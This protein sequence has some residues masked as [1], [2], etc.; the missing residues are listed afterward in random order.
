MTRE[1]RARKCTAPETE[2]IYPEIPGYG[3]SLGRKREA[4]RV[5]Y[6]SPNARQCECGA[7]PVFEQYTMDYGPEGERNVPATEF[8]AICPSCERRAKGSGSLEFCLNRWNNQIMSPDSMRVQKRPADFDT[9][10]CVALSGRLVRD[11]MEEAIRLVKRRWEIDRQLANPLLSDVRRELLY[12]EF[13][14]IRH[15][16][17]EMN[18]VFYGPITMDRDGDAIISKIRQKLYPALKPEERVTI[19]LRLERMKEWKT[20]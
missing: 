3:R 13:K 14:N 20:K 18:K 4:W 11:A 9:E 15:H 8:V 19:P 10:A 5:G 1:E 2:R 7:F 6:T 16:L 12:T 17:H